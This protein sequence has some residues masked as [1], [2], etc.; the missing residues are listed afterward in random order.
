MANTNVQF[1]VPLEAVKQTATPAAPDAGN[2]GLY[3]KTDDK[4]YLQTSAGVESILGG[5][6]QRT[7]AYWSA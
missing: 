7:F 6:T 1:G 3:P 4:W 5:S 2:L